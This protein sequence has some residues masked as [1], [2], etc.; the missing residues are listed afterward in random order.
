MKKSSNNNNNNAAASS[1]SNRSVSAT[2]AAAASASQ[3]PS[4]S[5]TTVITAGQQQLGPSS[6]QNSVV[7]DIT[8]TGELSFFEAFSNFEDQ[9]KLFNI[10]FVYLA[11]YVCCVGCGFETVGG[12]RRGVF[13]FGV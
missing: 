7:A 13:V 8:P 3:A 10:L 11:L 12:R 1:S 6:P 9:C 5:S 2:S 4:S